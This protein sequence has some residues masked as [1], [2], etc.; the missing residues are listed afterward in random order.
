MTYQQIDSAAK[1]L[2]NL[3]THLTDA[4]VPHSAS[5]GGLLALVRL[6]QNP[7][8]SRVSTAHA[9]LGGLLPLCL[10]D[11]GCNVSSMWHDQVVEDHKQS[12]HVTRA[13]VNLYM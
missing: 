12:V 10:A 9:A 13:T 11:A 7:L 2:R 4:A 1:L 8:S 3:A 5:C 6:L